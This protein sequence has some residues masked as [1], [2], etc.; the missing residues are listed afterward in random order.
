MK[1]TYTL[2]DAQWNRLVENVTAHFD[3]LTLKRGFQYYKQG[4]VQYMNMPN[5][6]SIESSVQGTAQYRVRINLEIFSES[7]CSCPVGRPCKHIVASLLEFAD[8]QGRSVFLLVN[9]KTNA[10]PKLTVKPSVYTAPSIKKNALT[11]RKEQEAALE[12]QARLIPNLSIPQWHDFF[13]LCTA[14]LAQNT[15]NAQYVADALESIHLAKLVLPS[16]LENF[17]VLHSHLFVLNKLTKQAYSPSGHHNSYLAYQIHHVASD[18]QDIIEQKI[19]EAQ[20]LT[21][22]PSNEHLIR[23]TLDYLRKEMLIQTD[24]YHYFLSHYMN[25][26]IYWVCPATPNT[27][28]YMEELQQLEAAAGKLNISHTSFSFTIA[29]IGMYLFQANDQEAWDRLD[30]IQEKI[31]HSAEFS[32]YFLSH[33]LKA[34]QWERLTLWLIKLAPFFSSFRNTRLPV[35][36]DYWESAIQHLPEAES[37]MWDTLVSM[38]PHSRPLYEEKLLARSAWKRWMDYHLSKGSDAL[39]FRVTELAPLEKNA[40]EVLLPFY[41]QAVERYVLNKNRDSYKAAV[42][43]LKRLAK[44]YKKTKQEPRWELY[45]QAFAIR[46]SRLRALQEELRK[47]KLL[48]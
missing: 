44:L 29:Q 17:F 13:E 26:W 34:E 32:L 21:S 27:L 41:H 6:F 43:L 7:R 19:T 4:C 11:I 10:E 15:R 14:R 25:V 16:S 48:L 2:D 1:Q 22:D 28:P 45:I 23:Q 8:L 31:D 39:D 37:Q 38:L 18:L 20:H 12:E 33:L 35:Y 5:S 9:A 47:G 42:K 30:I 36:S 46:N 3:D 40:P 24:D